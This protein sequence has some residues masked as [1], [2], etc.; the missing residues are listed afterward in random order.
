MNC[1]IANVDS[2]EFYFV[3]M[4]FDKILQILTKCDVNRFHLFDF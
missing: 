1:Y 2:T 3:L 4:N